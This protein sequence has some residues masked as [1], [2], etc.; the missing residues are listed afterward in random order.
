MTRSAVSSLV[1]WTLFWAGVAGCGAAL[2]HFGR[3]LSWGE[4]AFPAGCFLLM[5]IALFG[6]IQLA[7]KYRS[8]RSGIV[9]PAA[10]AWGE[11]VLG[12][13]YGLRWRLIPGYS[14]GD[15]RSFAIW[16]AA[17]VAF[18]VVVPPRWYARMGEIKCARCGHYHEG[19]DCI[20]GCRADQFR[21]GSFQPPS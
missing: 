15:L 14:R 13:Y 6:G 16:M 2:L 19:R 10:C 7:M 8:S 4:L 20:C 18:I 21:Y 5:Q 11:I 12:G 3:H 17:F 1:V 9:L